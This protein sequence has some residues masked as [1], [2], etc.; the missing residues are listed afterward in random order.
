MNRRPRIKLPKTRVRKT[1]N[2]ELQQIS[3]QNRA[4]IRL[5]GRQNVPRQRVR[6]RPN[7]RTQ[8]TLPQTV[9][10]RPPIQTTANNKSRII[11]REPL[12]PPLLGSINFRNISYNI[13]PGLQSTF[14]WLAPQAQGYDSYQF[15]SLHIEYKHTI[16][17]FTGLGR[18]VIAPDY[19][20]SDSPSTSMVQAEQ[21][22]DCVFDAVT[23]DCTC[24]LKPRGMGIIGPKRYTR[25]GLLPSN[26]DIKMYDVAQINVCTSG[27][28]SDTAEIGQ[29]WVVYD[30][31]LF[32]PQPTDTGDFAQSGV[33][34]NATGGNMLVTSLAGSPTLNTGLI[35]IV[36][37]L[38]VLTI[39]NLIP[40]Q[41]YILTCGVIA[42][43][44]TTQLT[45]TPTTGFTYDSG[46][47]NN[48]TTTSSICNQL[49]TATAT[50]A[51]L[52]MGGVTVLTG[53]DR[54]TFQIS[55]VA[56]LPGT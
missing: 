50:T 19:D 3:A 9:R 55:L 15:N 5:L 13:N 27:Q 39:S 28:A 36:P 49:W 56:P 54:F 32:E 25:P 40:Q 14:P 1:I 26:V 44:V 33:L 52:T 35:Q 30:I 48:A 6:N 17:E 46:F 11:H 37:A 41:Q 24:I 12:G 10:Y 8:M 51:T 18:L 42:G 34:E 47:I 7:N 21:Q 31:T 4:R 22:A 43:T 23:R 29:L 16:N 20:S 45:I 2:R 38:N 53:P